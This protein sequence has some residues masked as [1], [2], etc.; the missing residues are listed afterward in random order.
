MS[1][2]PSTATSSFTPIGTPAHTPGSSPRATAASI[3]AARAA[4]A[5]DVEEA[6]RV[7][8]VVELLDAREERVEQVDRLQLARAHAV[9]QLPRVALPQLGHATPPFGCDLRHLRERVFDPAREHLEIAA[10]VAV[11]PQPEVQRAVVG[12]D[13]DDDREVLRERHDRERLDQARAHHVE[14]LL[15]TGHVGDDQVH[16]RL[17]VHGARREAHQRRRDVVAHVQQQVGAQRLPLLLE[18]GGLLRDLAQAVD[19]VG[20]PDRERHEDRRDLV[21]ERAALVVGAH[22][23][24]AQHAQPEVVDVVAA[25]REQL[26][27]AAADTREHDVVDGAAERAAGSP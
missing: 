12:E 10:G 2:Q 4:R 14:R 9:G 11:G 24:R 25:R 26:V 18:V 5:V 27:Q 6:E 16:E 3:S 23:H 8:L 7:E 17:P 13:P 22:R 21:A 19:R 20:R 15:R 1:G